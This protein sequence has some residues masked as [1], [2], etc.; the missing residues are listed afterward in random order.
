MARARDWNLGDTTNRPEPRL[1]SIS[2]PEAPIL[3]PPTRDRVPVKE[4][5]ELFY[6]LHHSYDKLPAAARS[7]FRRWAWTFKPSNTKTEHS[8]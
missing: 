3:E 5:R 1:N 2:P 7:A 4:D 6:W 8:E